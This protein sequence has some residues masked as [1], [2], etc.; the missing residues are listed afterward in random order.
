M[1]VRIALSCV[2]IWFLLGCHGGTSTITPASPTPI[3]PSP[4]PVAPN[5]APRI[6]AAAIAPSLGVV[7]L[8]TFTAHVEAR[9]PDGD[10]LSIAWSDGAGHVVSDAQDVTFKAGAVLAPLTV[11]V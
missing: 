3:S 9:D 4:G 6:V 8:T 5:E 2:S 7:G 10:P 11:R 1:R